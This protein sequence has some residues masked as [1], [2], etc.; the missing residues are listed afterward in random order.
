MRTVPDLNRM[1]CDPDLID[2]TSL[3]PLPA[4]SPAHYEGMLDKVGKLGAHE[5]ALDGMK[6]EMARFARSLDHG[7][8]LERIAL[9]EFGPFALGS[10]EPRWTHFLSKYDVT[11]E[12]MGKAARP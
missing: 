1:A 10:E 2:H 12:S 3:W 11:A 8:S 4:L 9:T 7:A 5:R 6:P